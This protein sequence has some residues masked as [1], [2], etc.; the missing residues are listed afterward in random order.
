[1]RNKM[2]I[3][4][5]LVIL[6]LCSCSHKPPFHQSAEDLIQI[7]LI[8]NANSEN[9][10]LSTL[11]G[12][13]LTQFMNDLLELNCYKRFQPI[14]DFSELE[15]RIYYENGDVYIIGSGADGYI[16]QEELHINGWYYYEEKDL[17]VL[18]GAYTK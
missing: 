11:T 13:E 5:V 18:F 1:M 7:E 10:I 14:G 15:I 4:L 3:S 2:M 16:K 6:F 9:T 17:R 8:H 12:T